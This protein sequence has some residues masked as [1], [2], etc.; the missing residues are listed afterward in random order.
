MLGGVNAPLTSAPVTVWIAPGCTR[1]HWCQHLMPTVFQDSPEG[2][3]VRA[4][5]RRDGG[6]CSNA[7]ARSPIKDGHLDAAS[8]S[9]LTFVAD[10]CP[11]RVI[12]VER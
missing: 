10:G 1:C 11:V 9:F 6:T 4:E 12:K 8:A 2:S 3:L 5:A 7:A